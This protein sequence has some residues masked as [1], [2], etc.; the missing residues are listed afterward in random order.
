MTSKIDFPNLGRVRSILGLALLFAVAIS[1]A[2]ASAGL[3]FAGEDSQGRLNGWYVSISIHLSFLS[4]VRNRSNILPTFGYGVDVGHRWNDKAFFV[5]IE[6]NL[7]MRT[8]IRKGVALGALSI[9]PG[10]DVIYGDGFVHT[11]IAVGTSI[12]LFDTPLDKAGSVG[13]FLDLKP[14]GLR[15]K[16]N[17]H[18]ALQLDPLSFAVVA[19]VL[20][21]IPLIQLE[22]RTSFTTEVIP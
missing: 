22:Y 7:W 12:L 4:D 10:F 6:H 1:P 14:V 19:P 20:G 17:D 21:G 18:V 3:G 2:P 5:H 16:G 11:S 15:W 8:E 13:G 9:A